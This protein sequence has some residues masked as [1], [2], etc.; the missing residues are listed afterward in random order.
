MPNISLSNQEGERLGDVSLSETVFGVKPDQGLVHEVV[1]AEQANARRTIASTKTKG[2]VRGGGKKPWKQK[3]TGRARQGSTRSPQWVGG[4]IVFGP[5]SERNFHV[6]INKKSK[7]KAL[8]MALSDKLIQNN[9]MAVDT[10]NTEPSKTKRMAQT[11]KK[12]PVS[13]KVLFITPNSNPLLLRMVRNLPSTKLVTANSV[14][15]LDVLAYKSVVFL[16]DAIPVFEKL[17]T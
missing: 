9:L 6:K 2:E 16:K 12:L 8:F 3:G 14:G 1:V 13:G 4:G 10:I 15:L 5:T 7:R 17:Y 11:I